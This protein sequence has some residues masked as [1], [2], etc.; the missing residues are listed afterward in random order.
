MAPGFAIDN[1][2]VATDRSPITD[3]RPLIAHVLFCLDYGG[4][5]NGV[6]NLVNG[7][8]CERFRHAIIA[9]SHASDF[10]RRLRREDTGVYVINKRSGKDPKA[11]YRLFRLLRALRPTVVHTRNF[12]TLDCVLVAGLAGVPWRIH[13]EHGWDV[14]DPDGTRRRYRRIRRLLNPMIDRFVVVSRDLEHWMTGRVGINDSK[15][16]RICNGVDT[17][18]FRPAAAESRQLLPA[19]WRSSKTVVIG[20]VSR[21]SEIKDPLNLI[22]SFIELR[23]TPIGQRARLL[24]IGDGELKDKGLA[25]LREAGALEAAWLPGSRDDIPQLLRC[26]DLFVLSSRREGISN[27]LLEAMATGLPVIATATGGNLE[28]VQNE[29]SGRL[30]P[31]EDSAALAAA[32][33]EYVR[34]SGLRAAQGNA[35]R[36]LV[37]R[38]YSLQAMISDYSRLYSRYLPPPEEFG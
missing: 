23:A 11:Y 26:M 29:V 18:V 38:H 4:L 15:V 2:V 22:R 8:P 36:M 17:T 6:V 19:E 13:G 25:M 27:T 34:D 14:H 28:L 5:E 20:S 30:V 31:P 35:A 7:L 16:V 32:L 1:A 21:L 12:G 3:R 10:R 24:L 33:L 9:L 37:E